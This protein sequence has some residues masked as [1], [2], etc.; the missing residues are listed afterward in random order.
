MGK[1]LSVVGCAF[2][3]WRA[4]VVNRAGD[5]QPRSGFVQLQQHVAAQH[6]KELQHVSARLREF[7]QAHARELRGYKW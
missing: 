2:C 7:D 1:V 5:G 3:P 6:K 4:C